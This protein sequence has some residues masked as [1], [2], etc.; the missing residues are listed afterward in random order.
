[1]KKVLILGAGLVAKPL[2]RY[3][4]DQP[5]FK[6]EVASR[7]V[8]KAVKLIDSHPDGEAKEL[9][10]K[11]E[12]GLKKEI[13]DSD[14]V[15][16][17]VPYGF[18][19]KV[20]KFCIDFGKHMVTTSYV[21]ETMQNLDSEAKNAGILILNEVGLDPGI[22]HMEAMRIIHEVEEKGGEI[23]SF[24]SFCGGL[25]APEANTNPFGYKF[26]WSPIGVLLAGKNSA[27][28]LKDGQQ[29]LIPAE[30][31]FKDYAIIDIEGL[32]EFEGYPNRNSLPYI[33]IYGIQSTKTMLRGTLRN[34]GWCPT[35]KKM[36]DLQLLDEEEKEWGDITYKD[37]IRRLMDNPA[38]ED[39]KKALG[40]H[41]SIEEDSDIIQRL[42]WLGLLSDE[43]ITVSKGSALDIL[44]ARMLEKLQYEEGERD[45]IILQHQFI[46]S[47]PD[48]KK[49]K[50]TSTLI[51]FGIP[52]G[53]SSMART[54]GLPA[55]IA[56]RL[57]LE[58]KIEMTG[59]HI[60]IIPKIYT[61]ILQELKGMDITFKEKREK[62]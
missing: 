61:P 42:E 13:A 53:D 22:D 54:V 38:E 24:T 34:K 27:Q 48:D 37:F 44:G 3:L 5:D 59:V 9:N 25:P 8:S 26:S 33:Q 7:T 49:E 62:L 55:A 51:D 40:A 50:I 35:M 15:I 43:A 1:M 45:M 41:L 36:V 23:Q 10:L 29:V 31:L 52:D 20:A 58:G 21:S 60:P 46:A 12:E 39:I 2:V 47:Y 56:T 18:H 30:D 11:D 14:L 4:L 6:V 32:V 16:S 57:I 19:P 28:Y 17:M